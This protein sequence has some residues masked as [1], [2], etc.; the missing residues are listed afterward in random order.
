[1]LKQLDVKPTKTLPA[2]VVEV[3]LEGEAGAELEGGSVGQ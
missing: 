1:M 3:A 2:K